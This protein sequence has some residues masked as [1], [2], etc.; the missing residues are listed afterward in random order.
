MADIEN[1]DT[2][3]MRLVSNVAAG[4]DNGFTPATDYFDAGAVLGLRF[5]GQLRSRTGTIEI[6]AAIEFANTERG[7]SSFTTLG[8]IWVSA[9][10]YIDPAAFTDVSATAAGKQRARLGFLTRNTIGSGTGLSTC[11]AMG[12]FEV[13]FDDY[14]EVLLAWFTVVSASTTAVFFPASGWFDAADAA[15][16]RVPFE[17]RGLSGLLSVEPAYQTA[18]DKAIPDAAVTLGGALTA[19]GLGFPSAW[20]TPAVAGKQ[21]IRAGWSV[22]LTSG[23]TVGSAAVIGRVQM[24]NT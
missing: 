9:E 17:V 6:I 5:D 16:L 7:S 23:S 18:N 3:W 19:D 14:D 15:K 8:S 20:A 22:K 21:H 10:G 13:K 11:E 12:S 24:S 1:I 2:Q 4:G